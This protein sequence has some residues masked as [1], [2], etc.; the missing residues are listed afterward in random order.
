M[1]TPAETIQVIKLAYAQWPHVEPGPEIADL[2]HA[3][4]SPHPLPIV[5]AALSQVLRYA[6]YPPTVGELMTIIDGH[7][8]DAKHAAQL[9]WDGICTRVLGHEGAEHHALGQPMP[10]E[11]FTDDA[12][13]AAW[14]K[15]HQTI[16]NAP[17]EVARR[18]F[19]AAYREAAGPAAAIER[20]LQIVREIGDGAA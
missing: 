9:A 7:Q 4:L 17:A 15:T 3:M 19:L 20:P 8:P 10:R 18:A 11:L 2:W 13:H 12:A 16:R 6:K 5:S 1:T 14:R